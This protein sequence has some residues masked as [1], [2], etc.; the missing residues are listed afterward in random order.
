MAKVKKVNFAES[1]P[2]LLPKMS[3]SLLANLSIRSLCGV[4]R[5]CLCQF[6][7][8]YVKIAQLIFL[9]NIVFLFSHHFLQFMIQWVG[10][11]YNSLITLNM[12]V[13]H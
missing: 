11:F 8:F 1:Y 13:T 10:P 6:V 9:L 4:N 7:F 12:V 5:V 3:L 2:N